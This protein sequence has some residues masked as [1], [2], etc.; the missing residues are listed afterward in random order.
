MSQPVV[1]ISQGFF[2][3]Q[4][5]DIVSAQLREGMSSLE[6]A[7]RALPG[8]IH[9]YVSIDPVSSSMVNVSVWKSLEAAQQIS[10]LK[11]MLAQRDIFVG[12]GVTFQPV[13]NYSGLW[14]IDP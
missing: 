1:R 2:E 13:R 5:N 11:E 8:L 7:L 4:H 14:S 9:S 6:P 3:P 12:L 10:T